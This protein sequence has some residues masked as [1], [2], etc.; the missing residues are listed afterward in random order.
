MVRVTCRGL[1]LGLLVEC[2]GETL[3]VLSVKVGRWLVQRQHATV[4]AERLRQ[5][6]AYDQ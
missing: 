6:Q 1:G 5:R 3:D 4:E 2:E